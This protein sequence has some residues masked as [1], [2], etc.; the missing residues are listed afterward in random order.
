[1]LRIYILK[2]KQKVLK[3]FKTICNSNNTFLIWTSL[4][5]SLITQIKQF[6]INRENSILSSDYKSYF[7]KYI[8]FRCESISNI[9][10]IK[11]DNNI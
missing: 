9:C 3:L 6:T 4:K 7:Y 2:L 1:M 11:I 5:K 10:P 8:N